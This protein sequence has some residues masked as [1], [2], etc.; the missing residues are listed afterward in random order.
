M[1]AVSHR[2]FP[3]IMFVALAGGAA[4]AQENLDA[5]KSAAQLFASNCADCHRSPRGLA[6]EKFSWTL[7]NFLEQHYTS[8]SASARTLT[9]YLQ[10]FDPP[11]TKPSAKPN[12]KPDA[13]P[14]AKP[15]PG[16][17]AAPVEAR[18]MPK[19][20]MSTLMSWANKVI[21]AIE[22]EEPSMP[23]SGGGPRGRKSQPSQTSTSVPPPRPGSAPRE[24]DTP[25]FA[26]DASA[27]PGPVS[28]GAARRDAPHAQA[29]PGPVPQGTARHD[30]P[31]AP[32]TPGPLRQGAASARVAPVFSIPD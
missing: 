2:L 14:D 10:T 32:A 13:K 15:E 1:L 12:T 27:E 4:R 7:S 17:G 11:A 3:L 21:A 25:H 20:I 5:N 29:A 23:R 9:A 26:A 8:S 24:P 19:M 18:K 30:A 16:S 28:E 31:D 6:K 22:T